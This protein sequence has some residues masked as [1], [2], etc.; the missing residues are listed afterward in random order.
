LLK[1]TALVALIS[2][3]DLMFESK[4]INATTFLSAQAFG[5]ALILYYV[6]ARFIITPGMRTLERRLARK[7]SIG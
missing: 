4:Q 1:S 3:P 7:L 2:V 6:I 5:T